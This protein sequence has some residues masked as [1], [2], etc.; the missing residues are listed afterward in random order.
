MTDKI[1]ETTKPVEEAVEEKDNKKTT[2]KK[3][4][5]FAAIGA[6]IVAIIG[7]VIISGSE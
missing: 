6:V 1:E 2:L 3:V 7:I 4:G 5:I